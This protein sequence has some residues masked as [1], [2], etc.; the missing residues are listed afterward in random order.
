MRAPRRPGKHA[1]P[2]ALLHRSS[3]QIWGQT[4]ASDAMSEACQGHVLCQR[5]LR[6]CAL[7][8]SISLYYFRFCVLWLTALLA[9]V[10]ML[11]C[12][13]H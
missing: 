13:M 6:S 1:G 7:W 5:R 3:V 11:L 9:C 10:M 2:L 4:A 8:L 12:W